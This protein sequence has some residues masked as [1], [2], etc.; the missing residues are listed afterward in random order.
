M[1]EAGKA[2]QLIVDLR[3]NG[4]GVVLNVLHLLGMILP[5]DAEI[6]TFVN[7]RVAREWAEQG[8]D[9]KDIKGM[10]AFAKNKLKPQAGKLQPF[11]GKV[12]VLVNGGSGSGSEI[13]AAA[14]REVLGAPV[15][16]E[17]S[18]GAVLASMMVPVGSGFSLL[19][20]VFDYVTIKGDRLEGLGV[21]P[22][23]QAPT[24]AYVPKGMKDPGVENALA[25]LAKSGTKDGH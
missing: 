7:R 17:K 21:A 12:A 16:G 1:S 24:P 4:G 25:V 10:A 3:G 11:K 6:G 8:G 19:Y 20:P 5:A 15:I 14:F 9:P 23:A 2:K 13:A 22:D 18:A